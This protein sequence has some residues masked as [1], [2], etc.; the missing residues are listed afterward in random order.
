MYRRRSQT[1]QMSRNSHRA[2]AM[3]GSIGVHVTAMGN[4]VECEPSLLLPATPVPSWRGILYE[5]HET[6]RLLLAAI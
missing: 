6:G 4:V 5:Q 2:A 3:G 1:T